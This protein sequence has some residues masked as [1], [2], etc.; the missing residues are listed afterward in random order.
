[1][2]RILGLFAVA[3]L[4]SG[5]TKGNSDVRITEL[6]SFTSDAITGLLLGPS[7]NDAP[8]GNAQPDKPLLEK[9]KYEKAIISADGAGFQDISRGALTQDNMKQIGSRIVEEVNKRLKPAGFSAQGAPFPATTNE[10]KTLLVT[11]VPA[12]APSGSV[13]QR[14]R[15]DGHTMVLIRLTVTDPKTNEILAQRLYYS[16]SDVGSPGK[17]PTNTF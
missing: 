3:L 8:T 14:T 1:M 17:Q 5:C 4:L 9:G 16:G 2:K 11:L 15:G 7:P 12:T 10:E 6:V 13:A